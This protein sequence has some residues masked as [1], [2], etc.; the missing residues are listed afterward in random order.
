MYLFQIAAGLKVTLNVQIYAIAVGVEGDN[1]IGQVEHNLLIT[2]ETDNLYLPISATVMTAQRY[3][4]GLG[5]PAP[6][7][8][9]VSNKPPPGQ[10][11]IRP[12]KH[13]TGM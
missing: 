6:G 9:L 3:S 1:G 12:G 10:G 11:V 7:V 5:Q 13:Y 2:S 8:A 4:E